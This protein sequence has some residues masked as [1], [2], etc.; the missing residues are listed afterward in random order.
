MF[1]DWAP[2]VQAMAFTPGYKV[3][4]FDNTAQ[5]PCVIPAGTWDMTQVEWNGFVAPNSPFATVAISIGG[6]PSGGDV[7]F[8]NL[9]KV[10]GDIGVLNLNTTVA[11]VTIPETGANF[12]W[13]SG[14]MGDFP[15]LTNTGPAPFF[16]LSA[17]TPGTIFLIR[18]QG[19]LQGT[20]RAIEF[21]AGAGVIWL[22]LSDTTRVAA[23]MI[24]GTNPAA[25]INIF[26]VGNSGQVN[27]QAAFA[28]SLT[29]GTPAAFV[30]QVAWLRTWM[31]PA[32]INQA[33]AVPSTIAFTTGTG[34][35]MNVTL[36][37]NTTAGNIAQVLPVIRAAVPIGSLATV[38]G[39]LEST[40]L[41]VVIKNQLG[42]NAVNVT[43]AGGETIEGGGGPAA[44][45]AG[46]AR[47]F[48]SDGISNWIIVGGY[49]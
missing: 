41:I 43:P 15:T 42:G 2:L 4:Q 39:S 17:M 8:T 12:E 23:G 44:V 31:F 24:A 5:S 18:L 30:G 29:Y 38:A 33:A 21:G 45:P 28:G 1:S 40:G 26:A 36:R 22:T 19:A 25:S 11:P 6:A 46:G 27:R 48:M 35:G 16:D 32:P 20:V 14:P 7:V 3:L 10:G 47:I 34:L 9:R 49:L 37:L 13:G